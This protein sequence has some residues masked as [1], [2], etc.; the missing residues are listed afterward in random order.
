[1]YWLMGNWIPAADL[2]VLLRPTDL[3]R[4]AAAMLTPI[5]LEPAQ[6]ALNRNFHFEKPIDRYAGEGAGAGLQV[7]RFLGVD[8]QKRFVSVLRNVRLLNETNRIFRKDPFRVLESEADRTRRLM[9][10]EETNRDDFAE[11]FSISLFKDSGFGALPRTYEI[12]FDDQ[13][14][15]VAFGVKSRVDLARRIAASAHRRT[16]SAEYRKQMT[17]A[18]DIFDRP[19]PGFPSRATTYMTPSEFRLFEKQRRV[20]ET[21][22]AE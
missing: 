22:V 8:M 15:A 19:I 9:I 16:T 10:A 5:L 6:Q 11:G 20:N 12:R 17:K 18:F 3:N 13:K 2:M 1:M 21:R 4:V 14:R 7:D